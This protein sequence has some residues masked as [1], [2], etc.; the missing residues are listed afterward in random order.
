M[1]MITVELLLHYCLHFNIMQTRGWYERIILYLPIIKQIE[2]NSH[3]GLKARF[4]QKVCLKYRVMAVRHED[5]ILKLNRG[6]GRQYHILWPKTHS[7]HG[8]GCHHNLNRDWKL[9][10]YSQTWKYFTLLALAWPTLML[11]PVLKIKSKWVNAF[12]KKIKQRLFIFLTF[13]VCLEWF[14]KR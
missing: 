6:S 13:L 14:Y 9:S 5:I 7:H 1:M 8:L 11:P 10:D 2:D 4:W 3:I 12:W